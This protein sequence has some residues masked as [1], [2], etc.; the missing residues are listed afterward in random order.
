VGFGFR[1]VGMSV[2]TWSGGVHRDTHKHERDR[3]HA[4]TPAVCALLA[5]RISGIRRRGGR[6]LL[7]FLLVE[8][9]RCVGVCGGLLWV[10]R[11]E[12][13]RRACVYKTQAHI[14]N[15]HTWW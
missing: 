2:T 3:T 5:L 6:R 15:P 11:S 4:R 14:R 7:G 9:G 1:E 13:G 10:V 12:G 8:E